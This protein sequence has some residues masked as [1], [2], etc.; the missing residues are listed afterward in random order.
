MEFTDK[1]RRAFAGRPRDRQ[2]GADNAAL[3]GGL[4]NPIGAS[5]NFAIR[6]DNELISTPYI[7][8][9]ENPDGIDGETGGPD[10]RRLHLPS[11]Q[12]LAHLLK[13]GALPLR[14]ELISRSQVSA[15]LGQQALDQGLVAGSRASR[16]S[17]S[18]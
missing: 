14:L 3:N 11:A 1:G 5:H 10:L 2:R 18:S 9:R 15:T 17:R 16:S 7:N 4:Q 13:I 8:F 6:L 12:D